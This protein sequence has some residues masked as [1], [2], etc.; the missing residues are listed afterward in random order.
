MN[1]I[2]VGSVMTRNV[3]TVTPETSFREVVATM[4]EHDISAVPVVDR[5]GRPVGVVSEADIIA[6]Q[7]F[8]GGSDD[9][10]RHD[11]KARDRWYR[12]QGRNA[13]E[14]MTTPVRSV[15]ANEP[16]SSVARLL[17]KTGIRRVFVT[18]WYGRLVGV[19]SRRDLLRIYL[20]DDEEL[21]DEIVESLRGAG[22]ASVDV[23]VESGVAT[24]DGA[25]DGPGEAEEVSRLV[26]ASPGVIGVRDKLRRPADEKS[27][28]GA[29]P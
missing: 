28:I 23:R 10:P 22:F 29:L 2:A 7:E 9:L 19:V 17:A 24:V 8:H 1:E 16:V 4:A 20:R 6:K 27:W 12:A 14:V 11:R 5:R 13:A 18:S 3:V 25:V 15:Y 26:W 21:R